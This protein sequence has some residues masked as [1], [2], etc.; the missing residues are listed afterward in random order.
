MTWLNV[1]HLMN[2]WLMANNLWLSST[3]KKAPRLSAQ[4]RKSIAHPYQS[5]LID[6]QPLRLIA[7]SYQ[8]VTACNITCVM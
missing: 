7:G 8:P 4:F 2:M 5:W 6:S 3:G 1:I